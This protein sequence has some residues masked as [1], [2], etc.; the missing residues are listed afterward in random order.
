MSRRQSIVAGLDEAVAVGD[1]V[2][3]MATRIVVVGGGILGTM[4]AWFARRHGADVV[5]LERDA[6]PRR[7][8]V[9]NFGLI[10]VS[11][12]APGEELTAALRARQLWEEIANDVPDAGFRPAG[13][14]TI[15]LDPAEV[16][17]FAE[18]CARSDA[19]E[20]G[21]TLLTSVEAR[22]HNPA[23][24][25]SFEAALFC[26]RDAV[27]EP[28]QVLGAMRARLEADGGS[29]SSAGTTSSPSM[30]TPS[31]I[32]AGH[33]TMQTSSSPASATNTT[34]LPPRRSPGRRC[35]GSACK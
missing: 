24:G 9:R 8:S 7:A 22:H 13:S 20:R 21:F 18:V 33:A 35:G 17:V 31:S 3:R 25:G 2:R 30:I 16:K 12:R 14:L 23:L 32:S 11:G 1:H 27:V 26:D 4:H 28:G 29:A 34:A 6:R 5:H 15:A 10:W 19:V